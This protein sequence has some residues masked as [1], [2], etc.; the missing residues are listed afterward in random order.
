MEPFVYEVEIMLQPHVCNSTIIHRSDW[1]S[2]AYRPVET[3]TPT[4]ILYLERAA[5][6]LTRRGLSVPYLSINIPASRLRFM[7]PMNVR[8]Y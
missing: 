4:E 6:R 5:D 3:L 7:L 2:S 8:F 1:P